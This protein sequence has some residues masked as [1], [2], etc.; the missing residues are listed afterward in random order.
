MIANKTFA[1]GAAGRSRQTT[2]QAGAFRLERRWHRAKESR[3]KICSTGAAKAGL[4]ART[5]LSI[6]TS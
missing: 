2:R 6:N 1:P 5:S 3:V 4:K